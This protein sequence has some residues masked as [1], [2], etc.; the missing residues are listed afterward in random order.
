MVGIQETLPPHQQVPIS[1]KD[2]VPPTVGQQAA[3]TV[4]SLVGS[5][6]FIIFQTSGII[7]W[8]AINLS[9]VLAPWDPYPF[10]LLNLMLSLQAAYTAPM[11]LM[12]QNRQSE[13][14]R[15]IL[16]GDY[17]LDIS[18]NRVLLETLERIKAIEA[19]LETLKMPTE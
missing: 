17:E 13:K 10:I 6:R 8:A 9:G 16:Y 12:S 5:W 11:I 2:D 18:S 19:R 7:A 15:R 14:D 1:L 4:A 3:E